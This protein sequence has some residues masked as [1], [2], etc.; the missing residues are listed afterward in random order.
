MTPYLS[1][2]MGIGGNYRPDL[3]DRLW[4]SLAYN[5]GQSLRVGLSVEFVV[6]D[7]G[8]KLPLIDRHHGN[9]RVIHVPQSVHDALPNPHRLP[10][11]EFQ[12]KNV[13]IRRARGQWILSTNP[14]GIWS[15][16]LA[17][18]FR[19]YEIWYANPAGEE[20]YRINRHDT[21]DGKVYRICY[22]NGC[23]APGEDHS[24]QIDHRASKPGGLHFN[25]AGDFL[26][27]HRD[28]WFSMHGHPEVTFSHTVDGMSVYLA[29]TKGLKQIILPQPLY[30]PEH[31]RTLNLNVDGI[32]VCP[33][34]SDLEPHTKENDD[35]WGC[36]GMEFEETVL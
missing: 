19:R 23:F 30:H 6:C 26:L 3:L 4:Y 36:A 34:W 11:F 2:C 32:P 17:E 16:E 14:D 27:M 1:V 8:N 5:M 35:S 31:E 12:P 9:V 18:W 33:D 25:A 20:F 24:S 28:D 21:K 13:A 22:E 7:W 15:P 29:H 10:Y